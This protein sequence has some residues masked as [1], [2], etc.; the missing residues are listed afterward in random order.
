VSRCCP[1]NQLPLVLGPSFHH[2]RLQ[3]VRRALAFPDVVEK[4]FDFDPAPPVAT[5]VPGDEEPACNVADQFQFE[6]RAGR[7][8]CLDCCRRGRGHRGEVSGFQAERCHVVIPC[9]AGHSAGVGDLSG[10]G[11]PAGGGG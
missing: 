10:L 9:R 7:G 3:T 1:F 4:T 11:K 6:E 8:A 2:D 5:L